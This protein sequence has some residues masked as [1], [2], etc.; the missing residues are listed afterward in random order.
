VRPIIAERCAVC[1]AEKPTFA[2]FQQ[3]PGGVMLDTPERVKAAAQKIHQQTVATQA[4]PIG[5][6]TKMTPEERSLLA[7][8]L[9]AGAPIN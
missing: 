4:M 6:L 1:H 3:P 8:W 9:E 5:N 2:G 7:Q